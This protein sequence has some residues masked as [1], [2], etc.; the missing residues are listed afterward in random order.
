MLHGKVA[1]HVN[2]FRRLP[3]T[4][5]YLLFILAIAELSVRAYWGL[6][7]GSFMDAPNRIHLLWYPELKGVEPKRQDREFDVLLL[8]GST[9][10]NL[11]SRIQAALDEVIDGP[12]RV[13]NVAARAHTSLDSRSKYFH[14]DAARFDLVL[15]YHAINEARANNCPPGLFRDDYT[16][17]AWYRL[18]QPYDAGGR[19]ILAL[20]F[21]LEHMV[22]K[23]A[24]QIGLVE[25]VPKHAPREEWLDYGSDIKTATT[26]RRNLDWIADTAAE[27]G[28]PFV[29]LVFATYVPPGYTDQKFLD[30]QLGLAA[31][32][33]PNI[34]W[35]R[36]ENVVKAVATHNQAILDLRGREGVRVVDMRAAVPAQPRYW[37]DIC[38]LSDQGRDLWVAALVRKLAR[39]KRLPR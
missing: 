25:A 23:L 32:G 18:M 5:A 6:I 28:D 4:A 7:G 14:L 37:R 30:N 8:G 22:A 9:M 27:R 33:Q 36:T 1:E 34:L 21:T 12:V 17:Y 2:R 39:L 24:P 10:F 13:H 35:G 31:G 15:Y 19:R 38:H 29:A 16:H 3:R 20:P 11:G 26:F